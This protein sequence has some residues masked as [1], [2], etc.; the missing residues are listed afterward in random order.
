MAYIFYV[1]SEYKCENN[2]RIYYN[3]L[4]DLAKYCYCEINKNKKKN[5][6]NCVFVTS[7]CDSLFRP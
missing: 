4:F 2:T 5:V 3:I 6:E 1:H 7:Q